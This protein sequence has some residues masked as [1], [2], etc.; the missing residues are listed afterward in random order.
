MTASEVPNKKPSRQIRVPRWVAFLV[1][2]FV[3]LVVSPFMVGV[4]PGAISLISPR[5][6][7][8]ESSPATW[9]LLGLLPVVAGIAGLIWVFSVMLAQTFKLPAMVELEGTASVLVTHGPFAI[10]RNPMFLS[11]LTVWLGWALFFGSAVILTVSVVLWAVT[12]YFTVPPEER[13]LEG[14]F[15]DVIN[16]AYLPVCGGILCISETNAS[17]SSSVAF[18]RLRRSQVS[19]EIRT[20][21]VGKGLDHSNPS[22]LIVAVDFLPAGRARSWIS[23]LSF[24]KVMNV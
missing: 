22:P 14:R 15:G 5:Y 6:G 3:A 16:L 21:A 13:A 9:N 23:A 7:W 2:L 1:G 18:L 24:E 20:G 8:T 4:L 19:Y 12:N 10:S 11:G 17:R